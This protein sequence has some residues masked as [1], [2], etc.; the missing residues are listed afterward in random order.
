MSILTLILIVLRLPSIFEPHWNNSEGLF[1]STAYFMMKGFDLYKD[2]WTNKP[3]GTFF[4][5][6]L[7]DMLTGNVL[8]TVKILILIFSIGNLTLIFFL[9]KK[10][11]TR[12]VAVI[13][14]LVAAILL[15]LP[16]LNANIATSEHFFMFF[17]LL[18]I[19]F[20]FT[21]KK[22]FL[23]LSGL[24]F[25]LALLFSLRPI[26][27]LLAVVVFIAII[28]IR[29]TKSRAEN[30]QNTL[31]IF[32]GTI[33]P[34]LIS[35]FIFM[36]LEI[37]ND[38]FIYAYQKNLDIQLFENAKGL[39][40]LFFPNNLFTRSISFLTV[41]LIISLL[42][43]RKSL[44]R[45]YYFMSLWIL[46]VGFAILF[47]QRSFT[48]YL[49]QAIAPFSIALALTLRKIK[50]SS[51]IIRKI[52][53]LAFILL[54]IFFFLNLFTQGKTIRQDLKPYNY[55]SNFIK[56]LTGKTDTEKYTS[57]YGSDIHNMYRLNSY[58]QQVY[59]DQS[60]IYLWTDN[61]WL[62]KL[63]EVDTPSKYLNSYQALE[64]FGQTKSELIR[65]SPELIIITD[66]STNP[67]AL[68]NFLSQNYELDKTFEDNEIYMKIDSE[69]NSKSKNSHQNKS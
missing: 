34:L 59:P 8:L 45:N 44:K 32:L 63:A 30:L 31:L 56:Y 15:G 67:A 13:S 17:S 69:I 21:E 55:Y 20:V 3:P 27:T 6:Y 42:Y 18:G 66:S 46:F 54:S 19:Y 24:V 12:K 37:L 2:I 43:L 33:V 47:S 16:I 49:L 7:A 68:R 22:V 36:R 65:M 41:F 51:N 4:I 39:G 64:N 35:I 38:L 26:F 11:F 62:Y 23:F 48:S 52:R 50:N 5:Y 40:F 25:S 57:F 29:K 60:S 1:A 14:G 10:M 58:I 61:T 9:A 28:A 53:I